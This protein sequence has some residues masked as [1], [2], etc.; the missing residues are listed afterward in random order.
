MSSS[1]SKAAALSRS[2]VPTAPA[3]PRFSISSPAPLRPTRE[4]SASLASHRWPARRSGLRLR[5]RPHFSDR[6]AVCRLSVLDN[7]MVGALHRCRERCRGARSRAAHS[8]RARSWSEA[9]SARRDTDFAGSQAAR[10]RARPGDP[11]EAF[12]ARRSMAGLRPD[13]MRRDGWRCCAPSTGAKA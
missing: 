1:T 12:A 6:Q 7:V 9:R 10:S 4:R 11:A 3:R 13:G 8:R 5:H 2:S